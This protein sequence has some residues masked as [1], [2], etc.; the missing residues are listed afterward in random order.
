MKKQRRRRNKWCVEE[1]EVT[2]EKEYTT[3][4]W[5]FHRLTKILSS[6]QI[7]LSAF[8]RLRDHT[9][10]PWKKN[11][12]KWTLTIDDK[13]KENICRRKDKKK[14]AIRFYGGKTCTRK[15][16]GEEWKKNEKGWMRK[17]VEWGLKNVGKR[18][19]L[20]K[21]RMRNDEG[22]RKEKCIS[23]RRK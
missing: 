5:R 12:K 9:L 15:Q 21:K 6:N 4:D 1:K 22:E 8:S 3:F 10:L 14:E 19:C 11:K 20:A 16:R 7:Y 2:H 18:G 13:R 17:S 23:R